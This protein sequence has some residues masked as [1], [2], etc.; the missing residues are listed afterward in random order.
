M[1]ALEYLERRRRRKRRRR[2]R[3]SKRIAECD[4][5]PLM[6]FPSDVAA[7]I[8]NSCLDLECGKCIH[9]NPSGAIFCLNVVLHLLSADGR[10]G[11]DNTF[12]ELLSWGAAPSPNDA[13]LTADNFSKNLR[14]SA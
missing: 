4:G 10:S 7:F 12:A 8:W 6:I 13:V 2:R 5:T 9:R 3:R 1:E 14:E 11:S